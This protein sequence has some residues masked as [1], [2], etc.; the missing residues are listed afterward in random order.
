MHA[1][2]STF[3]GGIRSEVK[4][5]FCRIKVVLVMQNPLCRGAFVTT[6]M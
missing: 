6:K 2:G 4:G 3:G 5:D 1:I